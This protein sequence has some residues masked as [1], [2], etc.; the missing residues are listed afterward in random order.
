MPTSSKI[1]AGVT[2]KL[3]APFKGEGIVHAN[4]PSPW[5]GTLYQVEADEM[6]P[7]Y[8]VPNPRRKVWMHETYLTQEPK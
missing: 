1:A 7:L 6:L 2:V 5:G 8:G 3:R 4:M